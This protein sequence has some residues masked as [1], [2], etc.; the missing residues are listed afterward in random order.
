M[1]ENKIKLMILDDEEGIVDYFLKIF[2]SRGYDVVGVSKGEQAIDLYRA[3]QPDIVLIDIFL[4]DSK[5][6]GIDVLKGIKEINPNAVCIMITR[7]TDIEYINKAKENGADHY[8][9]KP[10]ALEDISRIIEKV[11]QKVTSNG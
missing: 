8:L 1:S 9:M 4:V 10:L 11:Q 6:D 2:R 7:V 3:E 5:M